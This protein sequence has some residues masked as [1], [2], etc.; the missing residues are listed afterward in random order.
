[1]PERSG[2]ILLYAT[3]AAIVLVA[4]GIGGY[5][6]KH[7]PVRDTLLVEVDATPAPT[8]STVSG[9]ITRIDGATYTLVTP[10]GR[11]ITLTLAPGT[12]VEALE[13]LS[14]ALDEGTTVNVGVE[15]TSYGQVLTGIVAVEGNPATAGVAR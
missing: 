7:D 1:M 9:S 5:V 4:S 15:D 11:E 12:A 3:L 8:P 14:E 6:Y 13:R 2:P 10:A